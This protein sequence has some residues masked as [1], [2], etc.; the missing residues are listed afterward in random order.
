MKNYKNRIIGIVLL[1]L[2]IVL[3]IFGF[4]YVQKQ[5]A[6]ANINS[7]EEC[8]AA[9]YPIMTSYPG[10]CRVPGGKSFTENIGNEL[11]F[12]D[13]ILMETPRPNQKISSPLKVK[14]KARGNW[15]FEASLS[16]ELYDNTNKS[17]GVVVLQAQGEWM[18]EDFVL[19][20]GELKFKPSATGNG[21]LLIKNANPSGLPKNEK[22]LN[23]PVYFY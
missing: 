8:V 2:A 11:E 14:G 22:T 18:T 6:I 15:F 3:A 9:G 10:Q 23:I 19:F 20:T 13:E 21:K 17:L 12:S 7:F 4:R 1:I 16:G 5:Q